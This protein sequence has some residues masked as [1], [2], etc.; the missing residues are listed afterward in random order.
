VLEMNVFKRPTRINVDTEFLSN[1][2]QSYD[3]D[4]VTL[5]TDEE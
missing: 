2:M 3:S 5:P 1:V 4:E